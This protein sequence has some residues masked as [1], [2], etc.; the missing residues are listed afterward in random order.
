MSDDDLIRR[1]DALM[2]CG[3]INRNDEALIVEGILRA[4]PAAPDTP[5]VLALVEALRS[6]LNFIENTEGEMG[7]ILGCGD[8]ARAALARVKG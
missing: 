5:E 2:V 4:L 3:T 1:G 8:K 7:V 6:T